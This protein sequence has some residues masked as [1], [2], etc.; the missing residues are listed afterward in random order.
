MIARLLSFLNTIPADKLAHFAGGA[1]LASAGLMVGLP[2]WLVTY[3][4]IVIA[5]GK[6]AYDYFHPDHTPDV[7]DAL[8]TMLGGATVLLPTFLTL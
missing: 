1:V 2:V 3:L 7:F 8:A 5:L 4:L 6:E